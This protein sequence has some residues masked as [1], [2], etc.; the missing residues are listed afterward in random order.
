M[1]DFIVISVDGIVPF[2]L[3]ST[4]TRMSCV[5]LVACPPSKGAAPGVNSLIIEIFFPSS[6]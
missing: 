2:I 4:A 3:G 1:V 6:H 5:A